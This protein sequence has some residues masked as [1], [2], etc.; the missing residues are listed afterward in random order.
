MTSS[1]VILLLDLILEELGNVLT[2]P[3]W[4]TLQKVYFNK[5]EDSDSIKG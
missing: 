2:N 1:R 4:Y 3:L 5:K